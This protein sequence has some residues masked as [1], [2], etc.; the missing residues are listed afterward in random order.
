MSRALR[1]NLCL[2]RP[3]N[4][5]QPR[6]SCTDEGK[7]ELGGGEH[8][9]TTQ[10]VEDDS[11]CL[12]DGHRSQ[13]Q[14]TTPDAPSPGTDDQRDDEDRERDADPRPGHEGEQRQAYG[15]RGITE[16]H[17]GARL[18]A[19]RIGLRAGPELMVHPSILDAEPAVHIRPWSEIRCGIS[20]PGQRCRGPR[21]EV[22]D[23]RARRAW[24][25]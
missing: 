18:C 9:G 15:E 13:R 19:R 21:A 7:G 8:D 12:E 16:K 25:A 5:D 17:S 14:G 2:L 24:T 23:A 20:T 11:G 6:H 3:C 4:C 10:G 1:R 22:L